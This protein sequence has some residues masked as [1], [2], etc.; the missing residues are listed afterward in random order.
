MGDI[1]NAFGVCFVSLGIGIVMGMAARLY[2]VHSH[3]LVPTCICNW[4]I[5]LK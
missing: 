3:F 1:H 5:A 4:F 2:T